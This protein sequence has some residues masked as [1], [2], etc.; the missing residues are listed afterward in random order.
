MSLA[1][2]KSYGYK[3]LLSGNFRGR[4]PDFTAEAGEPKNLLQIHRRYV[5]E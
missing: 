1:L 5:S 2:K 4:Y 3:K